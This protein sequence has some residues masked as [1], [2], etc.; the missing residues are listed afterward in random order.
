MPEN[1]IVGVD[2]TLTSDQI[3]KLEEYIDR[4]YPGKLPPGT[5]LTS[6]LSALATGVLADLADGAMLLG[7]AKTKRI[8]ELCGSPDQI[9]A[10]LEKAQGWEEGQY[11]I[12]VRLD[13]YWGEALRSLAEAKGWTLGELFKDAID[14][15]LA[16]LDWIYDVPD[17]PLTLLLTNEQYRAIAEALGVDQPTGQEVADYIMKH[18]AEPAFAA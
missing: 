8:L 2:L 1:R 3:R 17:K 18:E 5:P 9:V 6:K 12:P 13:P 4:Q 14:H 15:I 10:L 16:N 11:L 7:P